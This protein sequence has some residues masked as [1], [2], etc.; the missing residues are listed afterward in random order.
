MRKQT[1]ELIRKKMDYCLPHE[2]PK[3]H[4]RFSFLILVCMVC[5]F[6]PDCEINAM[7][8][9]KKFMPGFS[10]DIQPMVGIGYSKSI[11][12]VS[13]EN[14]QINSLGQDAA[15]ETIYTP[16][17]LWKVEYT[18]KNNAT[19][20]YAGTPTENFIEGNFLLETGLRQ[21]LSNGTVLTAAWIPKIPLL[22][23]EVWKDPFL[24]GSDR[25]ETDRYSQAFRV[26]MESILNTPLTL[27]YGFGKQEI[28]DE[29]S[30]DYLA[31]LPGS[32]LTLQDQELLKRDADY[33]QVEVLYGIGLGKQLF[34]RPGLYYML[35]NAEG[36][37]NS[38]NEFN[39]QVTLFYATGHY[40]FH[41]N[42]SFGKTKYKAVNPVFGQ[43]RDDL[44]YS[45]MLGGERTAPFGWKNFSVSV[46]TRYSRQDSNIG[47]YDEKAIMAGL[48]LI[49][50]F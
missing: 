29:Q 45:F 47:F 20:I 4:R 10:G 2:H 46:F 49:L 11:S 15:S 37:A 16:F 33:H 48:G 31:G 26:G 19:Q 50:K 27:K 8:R 44:K 43:T 25:V 18:F 1:K 3:T 21:K 42:I 41:G 35:G 6:Y 5:L 34:F 17:I 14:K 24:L 40:R 7:E 39:G 12:K 36:D 9:E 38:F 13:D 23:D 30:G 22:D 32:S 28:D